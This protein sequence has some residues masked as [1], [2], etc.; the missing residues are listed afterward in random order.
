MWYEWNELMLFWARVNLK[1]ELP[2]SDRISELENHF[3]DQWLRL[4]E[5]L[6][7]LR[8]YKVLSS[9]S[10]TSSSSSLF[11]STKY[12]INFIWSYDTPHL[13]SL[14]SSRTHLKGYGNAEIILCNLKYNAEISLNSINV[15][16]LLKLM[17]D[18]Y[19]FRWLEYGWMYPRNM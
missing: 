6:T 16:V 12:R 9:S 18:A 4:I 8:A 3:I 13:L 5:S 11:T 7:Y 17:A 14:C 1:S 15:C 10:F 2:Y 19:E